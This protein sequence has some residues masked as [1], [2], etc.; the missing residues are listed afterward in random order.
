[1]RKR[2]TPNKREKFSKFPYAWAETV[3]QSYRWVSPWHIRVKLTA[4]SHL[5]NHIVA[6]WKRVKS[7]WSRLVARKR[8]EKFSYSTTCSCSLATQIKK[9]T[10]SSALWAIQ[11][12][13]RNLKFKFWREIWLR[14]SFIASDSFGPSDAARRDEIWTRK[15]FS[16]FRSFSH[17]PHRPWQL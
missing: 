16:N 2:G 13:I 14:R 7:L 1:M 12:K 3:N 11:V 9:E 10:R 5:S 4:V 17:Q 6:L 8:R 15:Q